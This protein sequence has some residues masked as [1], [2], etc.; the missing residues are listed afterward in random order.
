MAATRFSL[1]VSDFRLIT[2]AHT[3]QS[4]LVFAPRSPC[5]RKTRLPVFTGTAGYI[6]SFY[7]LVCPVILKPFSR[8]WTLSPLSAG[9]HFIKVKCS[10]SLLLEDQSVLRIT[11]PWDDHVSQWE[12]RIWFV[13]ILYLV[14]IFW[15][16][17]QYLVLGPSGKSF[18][19]WDHRGV[20][21]GEV[22]WVC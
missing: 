1:G 20:G 13:I 11:H 22:P 21:P 15:G 6:S 5:I 7:V 10:K 17:P 18:V 14:Q 2:S 9:A 16:P 12:N 3:V 19:H 4:F 8:T